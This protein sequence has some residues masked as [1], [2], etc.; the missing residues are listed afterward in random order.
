MRELIHNQGM[1]AGLATHIKAIPV[2]KRYD[3]LARM[4][5]ERVGDN[6]ARFGTDHGKNLNRDY[7]VAEHLR[8][9]MNGD[10]G[11]EQGSLDWNIRDSLGL[12]RSRLTLK[13]VGKT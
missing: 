6:P 7:T 8:S 4:I 9:Y 2:L 11:P 3:V 12:A 13:K 1:V 5:R 10:K